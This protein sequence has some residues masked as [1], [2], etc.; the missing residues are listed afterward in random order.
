LSKVGRSQAI[1]TY[2]PVDETVRTG[3]AAASPMPSAAGLARTGNL[4]SVSSS[5]F[6]H[7]V[8][9]APLKTRR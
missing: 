7:L 1:L 4:L 5:R 8:D 9:I 3:L 2:W 6:R